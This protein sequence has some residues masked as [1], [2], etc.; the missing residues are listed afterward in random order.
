[1]HVTVRSGICQSVSTLA[2]LVRLF[3]HRFQLAVVRY[4]KEHTGGSKKSEKHFLPTTFPTPRTIN[5]RLSQDIFLLHLLSAY[6]LTPSALC[7]LLLPRHLTPWP[8]GAAHGLCSSGERRTKRGPW[9]FYE[10]K[11]VTKHSEGTSKRNSLPPGR[12]NWAHSRSRTE[13]KELR[14]F[15]LS[16]H[17]PAQRFIP[18]YTTVFTFALGKLKAGSLYFLAEFPKPQHSI[19]IF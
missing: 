1:M 16:Q 17:L 13:L 2:H 4:A 15:A 10:G 7:S 11:A 8:G 18:I 6:L 9:P 5:C 19:P 12:S 3:G 14:F